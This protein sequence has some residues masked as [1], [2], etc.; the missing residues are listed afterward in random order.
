MPALA[1][2]LQDNLDRGEHQDQATLAR[3]LGLTPTKVARLLDLVLLAPDIQEEVLFRE[4]VNSKEPVTERTLRKV[5]R[6]QSWT[7]QRKA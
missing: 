1:N 7:D 3:D 6:H 5:V 2:D 4:A